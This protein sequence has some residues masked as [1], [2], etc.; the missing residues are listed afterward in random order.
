[1]NLQGYGRIHMPIKRGFHEFEIPL[2]RPIPSTVLGQLLY[3]FG[4]QPELLEPKMLA[5]SV[6]TNREFIP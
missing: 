4:Y 5:S 2:F 3:Y 6:G 1:M